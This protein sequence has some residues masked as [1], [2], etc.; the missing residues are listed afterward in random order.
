MNLLLTLVTLTLIGYIIRR[1]IKVRNLNRYNKIDSLIYKHKLNPSAG[2]N[3]N[4]LHFK[5][6]GTMYTLLANGK[7]KDAEGRTVQAKELFK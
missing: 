1:V 7:I 5:I 3:K 4:E 2:I 6:N